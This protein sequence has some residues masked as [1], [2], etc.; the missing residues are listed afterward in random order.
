[1]YLNNFIPYIVYW[2]EKNNNLI[3]ISLVKKYIYLI[4]KS[5][6]AGTS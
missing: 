2:K 5:S 6:Y 3:F 1:M 4:S